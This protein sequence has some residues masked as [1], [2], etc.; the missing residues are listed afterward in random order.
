M[1]PTNLVLKKQEQ[2][3]INF[4]WDSDKNKL[5][6][7]YNLGDLAPRNQGPETRMKYQRSPK[8]S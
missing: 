2:E 6:D 1:G 8:L 3:T 5:L 4:P 7:V